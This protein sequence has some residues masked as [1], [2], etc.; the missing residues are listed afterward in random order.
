S[1]GK[2]PS[3]FR[4]ADERWRDVATR[5]E[6]AG[7]AEPLSGFAVMHRP[8]AIP[9]QLP[10]AEGAQELGPGIFFRQRRGEMLANNGISP[11]RSIGREVLDAVRAKY[12]AFGFEDRSHRCL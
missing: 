4:Y 6:E 10:L 9:E 5:F 7:L 1:R 3:G 12:E 2:R 8:V 11:H